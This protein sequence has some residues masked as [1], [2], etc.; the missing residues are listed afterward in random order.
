MTASMV[1]TFFSAAMRVFLSSAMTMG[2]ATALDSAKSEGIVQDTLRGPSAV[3][4]GPEF[5]A[6]GSG[7]GVSGVQDT[8][9]ASS[10]TAARG[11]IQRDTMHLRGDGAPA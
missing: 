9:A 4:A 5:D 10:A 1:S 3:T 2:R 6:E 11:R 8:S 7:S